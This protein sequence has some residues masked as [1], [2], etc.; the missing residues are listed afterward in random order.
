MGQVDGKVVL[1]TGAA[2]GQGRAEAERFVAEGAAVVLTDVLDAEG[3][4]A[5]GELGDAAVYAH[6]DVTDAGQW[7]AAV[8]LA[9]ERFGRLDTLVNNAGI[10][11]STPLRDTDEATFR[12]VL[13]V[14]LVGAFLG[15]QAVLPALEAAGGGS[16]VNVAS[17][18]GLRGIADS[19]AYAS[20]KFGLRG[21]TKVAAVDLGPLG[22]RVN[23]VLPGVIR[24]PMTAETLAE[25]E[26][27]IA[28]GLP[29]RRVGESLDVAGAVVWLASDAASFVTGVDLP[30]DGGS[31]AT[32]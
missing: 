27:T 2:R 29:L 23:A 10:Y 1:V 9:V 17:V 12:K 16:V 11:L 24:T 13:D 32:L 6:L 28:A 14:N 31:T 15:L 8:D 21:L 18:A 30:I 20:S 5:A 3:T 25:R 22:I 4:A 7:A 26:D 19:A